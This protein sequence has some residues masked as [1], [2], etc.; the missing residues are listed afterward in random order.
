MAEIMD[1]DSQPA[2]PYYSEP[3]SAWIV[4]RPADVDLIVRSHAFAD[5][6]PWRISGDPFPEAVSA[7]LW[8]ANAHPAALASA[9][10]SVLGTFN[11]QRRLFEARSLDVAQWSRPT[12]QGWAHLTSSEGYSRLGLA[13]ARSGLGGPPTNALTQALQQVRPSC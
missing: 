7:Y 8:A 11:E 4:S 12:R 1:D 9:D 2:P 10:P 3:D 6:P 5:I 13:T